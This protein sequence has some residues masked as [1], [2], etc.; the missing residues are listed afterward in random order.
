[1]DTPKFKLLSAASAA[2]RDT[3][4]NNLN[5]GVSTTAIAAITNTTGPVFQDAGAG[6]IGNSP[7]LS[8]YNNTDSTNESALSF[9]I[10][11][12][13]IAATEWPAIQTFDFTI[14]NF[15]IVL[16]QAGANEVVSLEYNSGEM[17]DYAGMTLDR[18]AATQ[19]ADIH[20]EIVDNQL[21]IDPTAGR[22]IIQNNC[23]FR[24]CIIY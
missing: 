4:D 13:G 6:V 9:G 24:R 19:R 20:M 23:W 18:N 16:E 14:G 1:V 17:E 21:N 10:G 11:Q 2:L 7:A 22:C 3:A 15:D 5:F 12:I 8:N